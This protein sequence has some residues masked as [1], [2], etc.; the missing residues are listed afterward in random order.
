MPLKLFSS[1]LE[2]LA[3]SCLLG[4]SERSF[5][6]LPLSPHFTPRL[7]LVL[8]R[9]PAWPVHHPP[10]SPLPPLLTFSQLPS[11]PPPWGSLMS[12]CRSLEGKVWP[13]QQLIAVARWIGVHGA[14]DLALNSQSPALLVLGSPPSR[15]TAG[16]SSSLLR[17]A[18]LQAQVRWTLRG[19]CP[20]PLSRRWFF[21]T[22]AYFSP[23]CCQG[24]THF[25]PGA[26]S[27]CGLAPVSLKM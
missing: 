3:A 14:P 13:R 2:A 20:W 27:Q 21:E 5:R 22:L 18:H 24:E 4:F 25:L 6:F 9:G 8:L 19:G 7:T 26:I 11:G 15:P 12:M 1:D 17:L 10:W 16:T 23:G